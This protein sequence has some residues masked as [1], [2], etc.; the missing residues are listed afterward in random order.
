[1]QGPDNVWDIWIIDADGFRVLIIAEYFPG[2]PADVK[3]ELRE[4]VESIRFE[5]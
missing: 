4:M 3:A 5:P 1:V 2:T